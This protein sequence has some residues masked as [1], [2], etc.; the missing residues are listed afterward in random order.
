[1]GIQEL[2][3]NCRSWWSGDGG[4]R[5]YS[6]CYDSGGKPKKIDDTNAHRN[7]IHIGLNWPGARKQTTFWRR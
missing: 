6:A 5:P 1:M 3:W 7:H 2:I 4:M